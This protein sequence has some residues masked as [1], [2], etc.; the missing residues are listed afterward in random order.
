MLLHPSAL[1]FH[2]CV[3]VLVGFHSQTSYTHFGLLEMYSVSQAGIL[4]RK[5]KLFVWQLKQSWSWPVASN[6][7]EWPV[8]TLSRQVTAD[9]RWRPGL[10][11]GPG[12]RFAQPHLKH[13][14]KGVVSWGK[15]SYYKKKKSWK[16][17]RW[18]F[19]PLLGNYTYYFCLFHGQSNIHD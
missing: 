2:L 11:L 8:L 7:P 15:C 16:G 6:R 10:T 1:S 17:T 9:S 12:D 19:N 5:R 13:S 4:R 14:R 18:L 3:L